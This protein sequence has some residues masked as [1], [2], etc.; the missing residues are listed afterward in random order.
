MILI[1]HRGNMGG[2]N[3]ATENS[4]EQIDKALAAGYDVEVDVWFIN[5]ELHLGHNGPDYLV[6]L[7]FFKKRIHSLWIHC[8]NIEAFL[9]F[10]QYP[11]VFNYFWHENDKIAFTSLRYIWAFPRNQPM[12]NSIAVMPEWHDDD[13]SQALGVCT[14]YPERYK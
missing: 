14:D 4:P 11:F 7:A 6:D 10:Y 1:S 5:G 8:K 3:P 9:Y 2:K 13:V 12:R